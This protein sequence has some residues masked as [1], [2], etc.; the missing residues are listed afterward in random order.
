MSDPRKRGKVVFGVPR[1]ERARRQLVAVVAASGLGWL[2]HAESSTIGLVAFVAVLVVYGLTIFRDG[3]REA[4]ERVK[5]RCSAIVSDV[6]DQ[7]DEE[8]RR[9][10]EQCHLAR[11]KQV[12]AA[13]AAAWR[14][15][16]NGQAGTLDEAMI[17]AVDAARRTK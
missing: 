8:L 13:A 16:S 10:Q 3:S 6:V 1:R 7:C 14:V 12:R 11:E 17:A 5:E 2:Y 9:I 4:E 15:G